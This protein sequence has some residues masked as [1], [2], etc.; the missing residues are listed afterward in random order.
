[1]KEKLEDFFFRPVDPLAATLFRLCFAAMLAYTFWPAGLAARSPSLSFVTSP[2]Y[3][4]LIYL[5]IAAFALGYRAR[6]V[7]I[8]LFFV[9]LPHDFLERGN[10]SRQVLL[11]ALFCFSFAKSIPVWRYLEKEVVASDYGPIWPIRLVQIQLSILYGVNALA[12]S[13]G[14]YLSGEALTNLSVSPNFLVDLSQGFL[15]LG[16]LRVPVFALAI[17]TVL[18]EWWLA[19]GFWPKRTRWITAIIGV[20]FHMTLKWVVKIF[21]LDSVSM[22]LYLSFLLP[23][24]IAEDPGDSKAES[25]SEAVPVGS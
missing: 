23:F 17:A 13:T 7:C 20:G 19:I 12:K 14:H 10:Q 2:P 16:P 4:A 6:T 5:L 15:V 24:E 3:F 25:S 22:F 21:M 9:L 1:M 11:T 18:T 8:V